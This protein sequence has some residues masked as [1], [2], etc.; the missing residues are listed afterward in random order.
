MTTEVR[1]KWQPLAVALGVFALAAIHVVTFLILASAVLAMLGY[2]AVGL[3]F[4]TGVILILGSLVV[5]VPRYLPSRRTHVVALAILAGV[6]CF[7]FFGGRLV[8]L[9]HY[10]T[11]LVLALTGGEDE[12]RSWAVGVLA[13]PREQTEYPVSSYRVDRQRWS[14][15]VRWLRPSK[16]SIEPMFKDGQQGVLLDYHIP[17][18]GL[19]IVIGPPGSVPPEDPGRAYAWLRIGDGLYLWSP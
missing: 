12:L 2:L 16:V 17:H 15:Q 1:I 13:Q 3:A 10:R 19:G 7:Y 18:E 6:F 9:L 5:N 8:D 4:L 14:P 11:R